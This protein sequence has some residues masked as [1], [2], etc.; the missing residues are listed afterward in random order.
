MLVQKKAWLELVNNSCN[1]TKQKNIG[2]AN[3]ISIKLNEQG[4]KF[5]MLEDKI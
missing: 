1:K 5:D 3:S 4:Q 2:W